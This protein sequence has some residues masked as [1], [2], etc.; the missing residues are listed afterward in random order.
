MLYFSIYVN[1]PEVNSTSRQRD[2]NSDTALVEAFSNNYVNCNN[3]VSR[4]KDF[5]GQQ[6]KKWKCSNYVAPYTTLIQS[7]G[8]GKSR[9]IKEL[10][11]EQTFV[12]MICCRS[13]EENGYP[14]RSFIAD[15]LLAMGDENLIFRRYIYLFASCLQL[16]NDFIT[17]PLQ[18]VKDICGDMGAASDFYKSIE[19]FDTDVLCDLWYKLQVAESMV[20]DTKY[21]G[22]GF[23]NHIITKMSQIEKNAFP[24]DGSITSKDA[25]ILSRSLSTVKNVI[26]E[27]KVE[28]SGA[29]IVFAFDEARN[30]IKGTGKETPLLFSLLRQ[31]LSCF[32][33]SYDKEVNVFAVM[34][35]TSTRLANFAPP[36]L[37]ADR[38][39]S[40]RIG[41]GTLFFPPW[42][43]LDTND[44]Q[45]QQF[46]EKG[47]KDEC[48]SH[49][50]IEQ[51]EKSILNKLSCTNSICNQ[52]DS[53]LY[54]MVYS[55]GRPLWGSFMK[56]YKKDDADVVSGVLEMATRKILCNFVTDVD[57]HVKS[58]LEP[59]STKYTPAFALVLFDIIYNFSIIAQFELSSVLVAD[60]M[61]TLLYVNDSRKWM[62]FDYPSEPVLADAAWLIWNK[63]TFATREM[64]DACILN[65]MRQGIVEGGKK[66]ELVG[67]MLLLDASRN[68]EVAHT[69]PI[70]VQT[71]L[72]NL[73][74][75]ESLMKA[76]Q[77]QVDDIVQEKFMN[78]IVF[79]S[80]F[81]DITFTP[82]LPQ[83]Q[84]YFTRG[85]AIG[86]RRNQTAI[87]LIIPVLLDA[88]TLSFSAILIQCRNYTTTDTKYVFAS[89]DITM[90]SAGIING[91]VDV[92]YLVLYMQLGYKTSKIVSLKNLQKNE[93]QNISPNEA[94]HYRKIDRKI[95]I[96]TSS[97][98]K[99]KTNSSEVNELCEIKSPITNT[100][101]E[102]T[103]DIK[104]QMIVGLFA[105]NYS[106]YWRRI[107]NEG[108]E[109][110]DERAVKK[111]SADVCSSEAHHL[112]KFL[113]AW[114]DP[115]HMFKND[116]RGQ[117]ALK[118]MMPLVYP[119]MEDNNK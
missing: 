109:N 110:T 47:I 33:D 17:D 112:S 6:A 84:K 59:A 40:L 111:R 13:K 86:C 106:T 49:S 88:R 100:T 22:V 12:I 50:T 56:A 72:N 7:S 94:D 20:Y 30:L 82:T 96:V 16:L 58:M 118:R 52:L 31:S 81:I 39:P 21:C 4:F 97:N 67:K 98:K 95:K 74:D 34:T 38:S 15:T 26:R 63:L 90:N 41:K 19:Y 87:D 25:E 28:V 29:G 36:Q 76:L 92:P 73:I 66:G 101:V 77:S 43:T 8:Y 24:L 119:P 27:K 80:H 10:S 71:L 69:K 9:L 60:F 2:N 5:L 48:D 65:Y 51:I 32:P 14:S 91:D 85:A 54:K 107:H 44:S 89:R 79:F 78:G 70:T 117:I 53:K 68:T 62:M 46:E 116:Y 99:K 115:L 45:L 113:N 75:H 61:A 55:Y 105:L 23:W 42:Y 108:D 57:A 104:Y 93:K 103:S 3:L 83:L 102:T 64:V 35:D 37:A 114:A 1:S 18:V 11:H